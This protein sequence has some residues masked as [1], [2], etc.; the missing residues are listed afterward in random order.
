MLRALLGFAT[1]V[2]IA[3][4]LSPSGYGNLMFLLGS[5]AAIRSLLDLGTSS[6]F[7]TFLSQRARDRRFFLLYF[8]WMAAQ[9]LLTFGLVA[10]IIPSSMLQKIWLGHERGTIVLAFVAAFLQQQLWPMAGQ[11]GE[12]MRKTVKVQLMSLGLALTYFA[13]AAILL[14][15]G[16]L[17][18]QNVLWLLVILYAGGAAVSWGVLNDPSAS[19]SPSGEANGTVLREYVRYCRPL[20]IL[21]VISFLY[22]F[23]DKWMLQ[24]FGGSVQQ[25]YFQIAGQFAAVSL[26]ATTSIL[27]IFWKEIAAASAA[28]EH[29][30]VERLYRKASRALVTA[31]AVLTGMLIPWAEPIVRLVLG[32]AYAGAWQ[33]LAI[34]FLYPI[35]QALGQIGGTTLLATGQTKRYL[36]VSVSMM[37]LSIPVSYL[38]LAPAA[39]SGIGGLELGAV[40]MA[41]KMVLL[42]VVS[43]NL[44]AWAIAR[45]NGWQFDWIYQPLAIC[46]MLA[47]GFMAKWLCQLIWPVGDMHLASMVVAMML[48][49]AFYLA[50]AAA[51]IAGMPWLAGM[52]HEEARKLMKDL[53]AGVK[54][55]FAWS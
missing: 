55:R 50:L 48:T 30:R 42:G 19:R 22:D 2:L 40:G 27:S 41:W 52:T 51:A 31:G 16:R 10:L 5:F 46:L 3:R 14:A 4:G 15:M 13:A 24:K 23:A 21:A 37:L 36:A 20:A 35:H 11:I 47:L 34:M 45:L 53:K 12:S 33:V 54:A 26:L 43:A 8:C 7:Y 29:E 44:Q 39:Q 6:A 25:G 28:G 32:T 1:G 49:G 17:G 9:F 38:V 18:V